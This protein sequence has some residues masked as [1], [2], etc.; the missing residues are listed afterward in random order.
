M[1][2]ARLKEVSGEKGVEGCQEKD[3]YV[4]TEQN[5]ARARLNRGKRGLREA[6]ENFH[7]KEIRKRKEEGNK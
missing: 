7:P 1:G 6:K 5:L 3:M 2:E 4:K